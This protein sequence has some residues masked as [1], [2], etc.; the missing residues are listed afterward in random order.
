MQAESRSRPSRWISVQVELVEG[1]GEHC[2]PRPGRIFAAAA[3]HSFADLGAAIDDAFARW[4][5]AHLHEFELADGA[6]IGIPDP[7]WQDDEPVKEPKPKPSDR[8]R[9]RSRE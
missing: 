3:D 5:R 1:R 9:K 6:R 8:E 4:D 7:Q 2:W